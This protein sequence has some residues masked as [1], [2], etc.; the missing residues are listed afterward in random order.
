MK[1][2]KVI[3]AAVIVVLLIIS[4]AVPG[5]L[6]AKQEHPPKD[7]LYNQIELFA[8]AVSLIRNNY[9]DVVDSKTLVYGALKGMLMALDSHSQFLDPEAFKEIQIETE[10]KFG[11]V[12]IEVTLKD[13]ILTIITAVEDTPAYKA[14]L[15]A[16][17]RIVR[18][19]GI[20]TRDAMLD[21]AVKRLRGDPGTDVRLTIL[22]ESEHKVFDVTIKRGI[23]S[24]QSVKNAHLLPG[25]IGYVR[26]VEFQENT[27]KDLAKALQELRRKGMESLILDLRNN[28]GGLLEMSV[29]VSELFLPPGSVV[30]STKGR[31]K[32][33]NALYKA[34]FKKPYLDFPLML[35]VNEGSASASEIVAGALKDNKRALI[36][37][38]RTFGK[39]SVQTVVPLGD[40]SGLRLTTAKYFTPSGKQIH[41]EGIAPD[42]AIAVPGKKVAVATEDNPDVEDELFDYVN[43]K[44]AT[45]VTQP[46]PVASDGQ[47]D[48]AVN[49]MRGI[50]AYGALNKHEARI[51]K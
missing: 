26:I 28:P 13:G 34:A 36:V 43:E 46:A 5:M 17:D 47:L 18:I 50:V 11:G 41:N 42:V 10:G 29:R 37:G 3:G 19:D 39:G 16:N 32:D 27:A 30:V 2:K 15:Q 40:G 48:E 35:L 14:G 24:V 51:S 20:S 6:L 45:A 22:R 23:I 38:A 8:G 31:V 44:T 33:Q 21:E 9:V 49:L 1:Y 25:A 7:D 4:V 12:G